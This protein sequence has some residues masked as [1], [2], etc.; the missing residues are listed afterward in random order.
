[1]KTR[2][3]FFLENL[4]KLVWFQ[5]GKYFVAPIQFGAFKDL[6]TIMYYAMKITCQYFYNLN[7]E[8]FFTENLVKNTVAIAF[9]A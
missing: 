3:I 4:C 8:A 9:L 5:T 1:M 6:L 2:A 7:A